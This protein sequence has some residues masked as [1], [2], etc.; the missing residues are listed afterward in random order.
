MQIPIIFKSRGYLPF[1]LENYLEFWNCYDHGSCW[2]ENK[3]NEIN[4]K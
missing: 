1:G 2:L 3:L 4:E